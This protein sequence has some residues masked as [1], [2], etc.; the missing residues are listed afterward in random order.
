[1]PKD[2]TYYV[3]QLHGALLLQA[4]SL[5]QQLD[6]AQEELAAAKAEL[7]ALKVPPPSPEAPTA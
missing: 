5:A 4:A 6:A 7:S 1:M 2:L 3:T